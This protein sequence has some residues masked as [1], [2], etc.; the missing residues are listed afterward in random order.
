MLVVQDLG[1]PM[2]RKG[3][4]H[5]AHS[6]QNSRGV[7]AEISFSLTSH[8]VVMWMNELWQSYYTSSQ[9]LAHS[10]YFVIVCYISYMFSS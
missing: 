1:A 9:W 7:V 6:T 4:S 5:D 8:C 3:A 2:N 10:K